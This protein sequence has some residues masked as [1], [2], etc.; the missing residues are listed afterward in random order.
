MHDAIAEFVASELGCRPSRVVKL[1]AF[2][3]NV[4]YDVDADGRG[5][6]VKASS[7]HDAL[8]AE[9]WACAR[10]AAVGCHAPPIIHFGCFGMGMTAVIMDRVAGQPIDAEHPALTEVGAELFRLHDVR[11]NGFGWLAEASWDE[12]GDPCPPQPSWLHFVQAIADETRS[13]ADRYE[14]ANAV[15]DAAESVIADHAD[16]LTA[17]KAGVLCHGDLKAT[18]ILADAGRLAAVID[19]GDALAADPWWD[20]ARF[21]HRSPAASLPLLMKG[22]GAT[23]DESVWRLPLYEALWMLVDA[24]IAH[25]NGHRVDATL[26]GAMDYLSAT[27]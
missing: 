12:H 25:R 24:C 16:E 20:I 6:I 7:N 11:I 22:Y 2:P 26:H 14:F 8:R 13:L 19:W 17:I 15:A 9:A 4:V 5:F 23:A 21:A 10:G 1:D 18:H 3:G 27:T